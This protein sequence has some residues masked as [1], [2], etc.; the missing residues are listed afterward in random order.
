MRLLHVMA[1]A[2]DGGAEMTMLDSVLALANTGAVT[3]YVVTR[4]NN[5]WRLDRFSE[6]G[7][8]YAT[9][10]LNPTLPALSRYKLARIID[11]FR[12]DVIQ[13]WKARAGR[14]TFS[15]HSARSVAWHGGTART[16]RLAGCAWHQGSSPGVIADFLTAGVDEHK[17]FLLP[18]FSGGIETAPLHRHEFGVPDRAPLALVLSRLHAKKGLN[19]LLDAI[20]MVD[21]LYLFIAGDGPMR[22]ALEAQIKAQRMDERIKLL[23]WRN[24]RIA[25]IQMADFVVCPSRIEPFGKTIIDAWAAGKPV[26]AADAVGPSTLIT[27]GETGLIV[28]RGD[29]EAM[30]RAMQQMIDFPDLRFK[31]GAAGRDAYN[32]EFSR[33]QFVGQMMAI[34][35][36]VIE[37]AGPFSR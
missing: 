3:Q 15:R 11:R 31:L 10:N 6:A 25:L 21:G 32:D 23:G 20:R 5:D 18:P 27:P 2:P 8:G 33:E 35:Q 7:I 16:N 30:A 36:R 17:A 26:I 9:T 4:S 28:R 14:F 29:D 13:Y 19:T 1:S 34:Y 24:D 22:G 37:E 12:P